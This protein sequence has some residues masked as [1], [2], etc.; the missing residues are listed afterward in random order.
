M[1]DL[2]RDD[3]AR[4]C[5]LERFHHM[6]AEERDVRLRQRSIR[7]IG[8][9]LYQL[10]GVTCGTRPSS[11]CG[12]GLI[13]RDIEQS[14]RES[15]AALM[16]RPAAPPEFAEPEA[17]DGGVSSAAPSPSRTAQHPNACRREIN[18]SA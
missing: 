5:L 16:W 8:P 1:G 14:L 6:T 17:Q 7:R 11:D 15:L 10:I 12:K 4:R 13:S 9:K 2:P 3:Y 18:F